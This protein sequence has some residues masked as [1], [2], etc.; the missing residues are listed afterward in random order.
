MKKQVIDAKKIVSDIRAGMNDAELMEKYGLSAKGL[1][2]AFTKLINSRLMAVEEIYGHPSRTGQDTVIIID[3]L[4]QLP[5]HYLSVAVTVYDPHNPD[6]AGELRDITEKGI[7][8][9]GIQ[10]RI[11]EIKTLVIDSRDYLDV[12]AIWFDAE[13]VWMQP[14]KTAGE[15]RGGF[16][17][18][19]ID[20][21]DLKRLRDL[22][23]LFSLK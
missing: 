2:S 21:Q 13:C 1:E 20:P 7:G 6:Q 3:D 16:Q 9:T 17:I 8:I 19:R 4:R 12:G 18:K 10:A 5:R 15:W 11:G 23:G 22:I 14:G